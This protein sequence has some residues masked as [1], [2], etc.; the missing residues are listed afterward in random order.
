MRIERASAVW[1]G[2][3]YIIATAAGVM[4][5]AAGGGIPQG[6]AIAADFAAQE[7]GVLGMALMLFVMAAAV[8]GVAFM[9]YPILIEDART[10]VQ[11]GLS[12]WYVG[13][14]IAEGTMF[15]VA[16]LGLFAVLALSKELT[17]GGAVE[18]FEVAGA[19]LWS[20]YEWAWVLGQSAFC[21]GAIMLYYLLF[22]SQRVP[23]WLS[24][25]GLIAAPLMLVAGFSLAF[26]GDPNSTFSTVF[27]MPLAL[28]EMVLA[29][30]LI[31][32]GFNAPR[33]V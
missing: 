11:E 21:L 28:Q 16:L 25:W 8:S 10:K 9:M 20:A 2:V 5:V 13:T 12:I 18:G 14:R 23:R 19:A 6:P 33:L 32:K 3:L 4:S 22:R 26:T 7:S 15:L 30:W 1:V 29:I 31:A 27:Y 24:V 17:G